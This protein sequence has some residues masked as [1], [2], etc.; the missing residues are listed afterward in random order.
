MPSLS[1]LRR[2]G[3]ERTTFAVLAVAVASFVMLQSL[4][5]P[6][7]AQLQVEYETDQATVT[8]VLTAYLLSASIATPLVGRLG[9]AVGKRRVLVVALVLLTVGSALAA[10]APTIGWLIA[11][12]AVQGV[13]GGVMPLAFG[14]I[15]DEFS[16]PASTAR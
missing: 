13:G 15:R 1:T 11:A 14:I 3:D 16:P 8:W 6:V 10:L 5:V 9:D 4:V 12:R 2:R 7:L